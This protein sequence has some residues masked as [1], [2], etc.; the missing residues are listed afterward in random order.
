VSWG[1]PRHC[2]GASRCLCSRRSPSDLMESGGTARGRGPLRRGCGR[3]RAPPP[4]DRLGAVLG[5]VDNSWPLSGGVIPAQCL[6]RRTAGRVRLTMMQR[7]APPADVW[8]DRRLT[9][10]PSRIEGRGLFATEAIAAETVVVR[11]GGRLVS[12]AELADLLARANADPAAPYVDTIT[13]FEDAHLVIPPGTKVHF[14]NHSCDPNTWHV[15]PYGVATRRDIHAGEEVTIDYGTTSGAPGF[16]MPCKC[17]SDLCRYEVTSE[18]W[19]RPELQDRYGNHW[20]PA[21]R[22]RISR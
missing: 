16:S 19:R 9:V 22:A 2:C 13:V 4:C 20:V 10:L 11:L 7:E 15:G 1:E 21:L 14:G 5:D 12:S 6:C 18:D 17:R 8:I 3:T